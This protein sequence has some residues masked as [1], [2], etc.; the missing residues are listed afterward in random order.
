M[1]KIDYTVFFQ[2]ANFLILLFILNIVLFRPIRKILGQRKDEMTALKQRI[3]DFLKKFGRHEKDLKENMVEARKEGYQE[4]EGLK[5]AGL[6]QE[7]TMLQEAT[8][9]A[10]EKIAVAKEEIQQK[11]ADARQSLETEVAAF[12]KELAEK[13]LGRSI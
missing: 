7:K 10:E 8:S 4:K 5:S 6:E 11:A 2:I 1:L 13:I 3:E 12:S 9:S